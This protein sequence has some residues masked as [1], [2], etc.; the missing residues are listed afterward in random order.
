MKKV[1]V[2]L[3]FVCL[4]NLHPAK[5]DKLE[6]TC[7]KRR[8]NLVDAAYEVIA[9]VLSSQLSTLNFVVPDKFAQKEFVEDLLHESFMSLKIAVRI[10]VSLRANVV[11]GR[12]KRGTVFVIA[13]FKEFETLFEK[14]AESL[15][16]SSGLFIIILLN[17]EI[18]EIQNIFQLLWSMQISNVNVIFGNSNGTISIETF[19]PFNLKSCN[20]TTPILINEYRNG[21]FANGLDKFFPDKMKNLHNC[22]IRFSIFH[23][24]E[25]YVIPRRMPSGEYRYS[26]RDISIIETLSENLNFRINYSY[27]GNDVYTCG[28]LSVDGPLRALLQGEA[29]LSVSNWFQKINCLEHFDSTSSYTGE[30]IIFIV[31]TPGMWSSLEKL[32][33]PFSVKLWFLI[34]ASFLIGSIV[35]LLIKRRSNSDQEFVFG[36]GVVHPF[37]NMFIGFIGGN[38][39]VLPRTNFARFLVIMLLLMS[40]VLRTLYQGMFYE[41]SHKR[42]KDIETIDEMVEQGFTF[43]TIHGFADLFRDSEITKNRF[44]LHSAMLLT[45]SSSNCFLDTKQSRQLRGKI[46]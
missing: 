3:H 18:R 9:E 16:K 30:Q 24:T 45:K 14:A 23:N 20:D 13:Q 1:F 46:S 43:Y 38:Q 31:P 35:I 11:K 19:M 26:G 6:V 22:S 10:D 7:F 27:V 8:S 17:G 28:N 37:F 44:S 40:L 39:K 4:S 29:D 33:N 41:Q 21:K 42:H 12:R 15:L 36:S 5:F 34:F 2:L 32:M 25:P